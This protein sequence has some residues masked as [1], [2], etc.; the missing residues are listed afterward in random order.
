MLGFFSKCIEVK[1]KSWVQLM[2]CLCKT[3]LFL[4][5]MKS[6]QRLPVVEEGRGE[7]QGEEAASMPMSELLARAD[8]EEIE[9]KRG[10]PPQMQ[11]PNEK[12]QTTKYTRRGKNQSKLMLFI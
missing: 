10:D 11:V 3:F 12:T 4:S 8:L 7:G 2:V 9:A 6:V 1:T 5:T